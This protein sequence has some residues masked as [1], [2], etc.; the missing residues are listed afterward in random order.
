[1]ALVV[2]A[3]ADGRHRLGRGVVEAGRQRRDLGQAEEV[4]DRLA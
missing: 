3:D 4:G 1:M 2:L